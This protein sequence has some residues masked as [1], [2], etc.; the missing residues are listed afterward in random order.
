MNAHKEDLYPEVAASGGLVAALRQAAELRGCDIGLPPWA[1]DAVGIETTRGYLSVD[2]AAEERLFRLRT[3][4]PDFGWDIGSTDDLGT[5]VEAIAAWREGVPIGELK[6]RFDFLDLDEFTG[7]LEA[8][9][10]TSSQWANL[11][12]SEYYRGQRSLL[13]RLHADEVL[14]NAFPTM[15]HR[16]VRLQVDPMHWMSR[17]VRVHEP[18]EGRYEV[19]RVGVPGADWTEVPGGDLV[20]HLRAALYDDDQS[21]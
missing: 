11:L 19:V 2:T 10:P 3:H 18:D 8:G 17:Q 13:L 4:I 12:S 14:R 15:T 16:T 20:A 21:S 9:E 6:E 5:L 7:A 1:T